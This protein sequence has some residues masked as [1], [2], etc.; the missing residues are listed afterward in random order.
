MMAIFLS[1]FVL[2]AT[3]S[4]RHLQHYERDSIDYTEREREREKK[5]AA[6]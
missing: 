1:I 4:Q 5:K 3:T 6:K 2:I